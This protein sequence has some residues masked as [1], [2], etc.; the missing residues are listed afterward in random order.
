MIQE[1][2]FWVHT[3]KNWRQIYEETRTHIDS[4]ITHSSQEAEA[5]QMSTDR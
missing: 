5:T 3:Q 4:S 1:L 2:H